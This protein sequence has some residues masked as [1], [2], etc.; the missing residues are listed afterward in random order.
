MDAIKQAI[1][2]ESTTGKVRPEPLYKILLSL[3]DVLQ[4]QTPVEAPPVVQAEPPPPPAPEPA[5]APEPE[6]EPPAVPEPEPEASVRMFGR[7]A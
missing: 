4:T 1:L 2:Q 5:P 7:T 3:V 6:P